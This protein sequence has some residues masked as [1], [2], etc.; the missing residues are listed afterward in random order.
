MLKV[1]LISIQIQTKTKKQTQ[2]FFAKNFESTK[3]SLATITEVP[4]SVSHEV[5]GAGCSWA[6][7]SQL[8]A[9]TLF[10]EGAD[11]SWIVRSLFPRNTWHWCSKN[12]FWQHASASKYSLGIFTPKN[13]ILTKRHPET[14]WLKKYFSQEVK[15]PGC[16]RMMQQ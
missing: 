10:P 5:R 11:S 1:V 14:Y 16:Q 15:V 8:T 9:K 2:L 7:P 13:I 3:L 4:G 6:S 12:I